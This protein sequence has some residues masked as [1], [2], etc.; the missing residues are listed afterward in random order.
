MSH[1]NTATWV[2]MALYK[3]GLRSCSLPTIVQEPSHLVL[4]RF[5]GYVPRLV[6]YVPPLV[7][8]YAAFVDLRRTMAGHKSMLLFTYTTVLWLTYLLAALTKGPSLNR[9]RHVKPTWT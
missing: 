7:R 8:T 6:G 5:V 1:N 2:K 4:V 9:T 3:L